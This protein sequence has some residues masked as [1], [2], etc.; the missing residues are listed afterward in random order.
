MRAG[1]IPLLALVTLSCLLPDTG[2]A[3]E[4]E[5]GAFWEYRWSQSKATWSY[6]TRYEHGRIRFRLGSPSLLDG[7]LMYDLET[8]G[9]THYIRGIT[10]L[11]ENPF[12]P[13]WDR[14][15]V[16]PTGGVWVTEAGSDVRVRVFRSTPG[17]QSGQK[18]LFNY[19][20]ATANTLVR[21]TTVEND[22]WSGTA[23]EQV[24]SESESPS[25]TPLPDGGYVCVGEDYAYSTRRDYWHGQLGP[26][27]AYYISSWID[28]SIPAGSTTERDIGLVGTSFQGDPDPAYE[29]EAEP[30]SFEE[31][32]PLPAADTL[33][34]TVHEADDSYPIFITGVTSDLPVH[35]WFTFNLVNS[36]QVTVSIEWDPSFGSTD[37]DLV[38]TNYAL[39]QAMDWSLDDNVSSGVRRE[40]VSAW[41]GPGD[42]RVGV[43]GFDT[44]ELAVEYVMTHDVPIAGVTVVASPP[45]IQQGQSSTVS[46]SSTNVGSCTYVAQ[47]V[48][49][50]P[51]FGQNV[52]PSG[53]RTVSP[54]SDVIFS[55]YC[56]NVQG[57]SDSDSV[58]LFVPEPGAPALAAAALGA[59]CA[60]RA[61]RRR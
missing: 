2:S 5:K 20:D 17:S 49:G 34:G 21:S 43:S 7:I 28:N 60:L 33:A 11:R 37:L 44:N 59:L 29:L 36:R 19:F 3:I 1:R 53:T 50:P 40:S 8:S 27:G 42:W 32:M 52:G 12:M 55:L 13:I 24:Q 61:A 39:T 15:G 31:P 45:R 6:P 30:S 23:S 41:L 57:S 51:A 22:F 38:L 48:G 18:A 35:D 46:W 26:V 16:D 4:L 58:R 25:C 14:M 54:V 56:N 47:R 9:R 10:Q